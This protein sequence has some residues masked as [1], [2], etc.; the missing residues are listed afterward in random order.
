[1]SEQLEFPDFPRSASKIVLFVFFKFTLRCAVTG[2]MHEKVCMLRCA[3]ILFG[4][5]VMG[6]RLRSYAL[7]AISGDPEVAIGQCKG[8]VVTLAR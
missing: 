6:T 2:H 7:V 8:R 4:D 3:H 5:T 1:M